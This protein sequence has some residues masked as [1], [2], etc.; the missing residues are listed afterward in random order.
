LLAAV[1]TSAY[2]VR[3]QGVPTESAAGE[4]P[5]AGAR[6]DLRGIMGFEKIDGDGRQ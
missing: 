2:T 6:L 1:Y 4:L 5:F 3:G